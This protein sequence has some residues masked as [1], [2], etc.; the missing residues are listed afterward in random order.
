MWSDQISQFL[1]LSYQKT[2]NSTLVTRTL[3]CPPAA[4]TWTPD[5]TP[6]ALTSNMF[7]SPCWPPQQTALRPSSYS[8]LKPGIIQMVS[9]APIPHNVKVLAAQSCPTLCDPIDLGHQAPLFMEFSRQEFWNGLPFPSP[10]D[11][12]DPR[13]EP[14]SPSLQAEFFPSEPPGSPI[15][16]NNKL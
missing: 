16:I 7:F 2:T 1:R 8:S 4:Q 13:I 12:P 6:P 14:V 3:F 5:T 15:F 9:L 10:G 11:F